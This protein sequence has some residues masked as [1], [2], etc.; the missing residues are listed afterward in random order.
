MAKRQKFDNERSRARVTGWGLSAL[1]I[2]SGLSQANTQLFSR[3]SVLEKAINSNRYLMERTDTASRGSIVSSDG[4]VLARTENQFEFS[5]N[6]EDVPSAKGFFVDLGAAAGVTPSELELANFG[7]KRLYF[8]KML[9][10]SQAKNVERVRQAWGADGVSLKRKTSRVYPMGA[11]TSGLI[12][13][14]QIPRDDNGKPLKDP[15]THEYL[16][17]RGTT[18]LE[19][20]QDAVLSG[21][22]GKRV[23][24]VDKDGAFLPLRTKDSYPRKDGALIQLT[25]D[26]QLQQ[27]A[28]TEIQ[29]AVQIHHATSGCVI[30]MEPATGDLLACAQWPAFD[31][32]KAPEAADWNPAY[33]ATYEPGST[34]K[35]LTL[36]RALDCGAVQVGDHIDSN[37][38]WTYQ[39]STIHDSHPVTGSVS[40]EKAIAKSSNVLAAHWAVATGRERFRAFI[41]DIGITE[42][43]GIGVKKEF[44]GSYVRSDTS[45][46]Q[47]MNMGFGQGMKATPASLA[48]AFSMIAN[49]GF[50]MRP[51]LLKSIDGKEQPI[52]KGKQIVKPAIANYVLQLMESV[53]D[54]EGGTG[55]KLKIPGYRLAGKTGTAQK[56]GAAGGGYVANFVGFV[57][58]QKPKAMILVMIDHPQGDYYGG[59]VSGPVFKELARDVI[60][61]FRIQPQVSTLPEAG[62]S[63]AART[64]TLMTDAEAEFALWKPFLARYGLCQAP[65]PLDTLSTNETQ[66][67]SQR[68]PS[69]R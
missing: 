29:K 2:V 34:F 56:V 42:P 69:N 22:D 36:A 25:I 45:P 60:Q 18:A 16:P 32:E 38:A 67:T 44:T 20:G 43:T 50:Q 6:F 17:P 46:M 35:I 66:P 40:Q 59:S 37:G 23:G 8:Q 27:R 39:G 14:M 68:S 33:M 10:D 4:R 49:E 57:P 26:S 64:K 3:S 28:S 48:S 52:R 62:E 9:N 31:P 7:G 54:G 53:I 65:D 21:S 30:I 51:R 19:G 5:V 1:F 24:M 55:S 13:L 41:D 61:H 11:M 47:L 12:G 15:R 58:A 63:V